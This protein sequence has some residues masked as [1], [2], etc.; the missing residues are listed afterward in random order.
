MENLLNKFKAKKP[1]IV[2]E[3]QDEETGA[4]G[5]IVINS[6]RNGAAGGNKN[7]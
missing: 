1:E 5:W 6:L 2:F 7:A 4:E 3:W